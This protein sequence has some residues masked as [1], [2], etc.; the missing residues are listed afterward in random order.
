M[1]FCALHCLL[2]QDELIEN[3]IVAHLNHIE[4]D[5]DMEVRVRAARILLDVVKHCK[6]HACLELI[7]Q[8]HKVS[9]A[10]RIQFT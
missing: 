10:M 1:T 8:L 5:G 9:G 6:T 2:L 3:V 7:D 4:A